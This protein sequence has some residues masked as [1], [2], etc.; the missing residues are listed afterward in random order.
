ME[1]YGNVLHM[2][3]SDVQECYMTLIENPASKQSERIDII[4]KNCKKRTWAMLENLEDEEFYKIVRKKIENLSSGMNKAEK[5]GGY[6]GEMLKFYFEEK[7]PIA[8]RLENYLRDLL[9]K[10][11]NSIKKKKTD[12]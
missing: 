4:L 12:L 10:K 2:K 7:L 11:S 9:T 8:H 1:V 3:A 5:L 6:E